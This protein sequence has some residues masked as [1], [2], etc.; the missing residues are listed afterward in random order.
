MEEDSFLLVFRDN[1]GSLSYKKPSLARLPQL[2]QLNAPSIVD[3]VDQWLSVPTR[4]TISC[5]IKDVWAQSP[6]SPPSL[7]LIEDEDAVYVHKWWLTSPLNSPLPSLCSAW[8]VLCG[9]LSWTTPGWC[10]VGTVLQ[11]NDVL[12]D[13]KLMADKRAGLSSQ[14]L[15]YAD[16]WTRLL[17]AS[18]AM[19]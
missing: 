5:T 16:C 19:Q 10:T 6:S 12:V 9:A 15:L 1:H 3:P 18:N 4:V 11:L 13:P 2:L 17:V 8:L 14:A 7:L